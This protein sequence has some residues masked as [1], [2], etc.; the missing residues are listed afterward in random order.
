MGLNEDMPMGTQ[1]AFIIGRRLRKLN[2]QAAPLVAEVVKDEMLVNTAEGHGF[3]NDVYVAKYT[4]AYAKRRW[5]K[6]DSPVN[7]R[8]S[9]FSL[10]TAHV[11]F[12]G[13]GGLISFNS[14]GNIFRFHHDGT[15]RGDKMRSI[16]PKTVRSLPKSVKLTALKE[17]R[18][19]LSGQQ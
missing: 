4:P 11:S 15:A 17:G 1:W 6:K 5:D 14:K 3:G 7:L 13:I 12:D 9:D 10:E 18:R 2:E 16:F 8:D 19:V